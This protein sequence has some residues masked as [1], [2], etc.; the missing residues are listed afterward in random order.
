MKRS[1]H[2]PEQIILAF[3]VAAG[4]AIAVFEAQDAALAAAEPG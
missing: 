3:L 4:A 1:R 2:T